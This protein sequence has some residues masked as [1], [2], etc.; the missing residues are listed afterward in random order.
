M[1]TKIYLLF[2]FICL[3]VISCDISKKVVQTDQEEQITL[4]K[5]K[6]S[7]K[8][9]LHYNF[10][11][12]LESYTQIYSR[13]PKNAED[14][15]IFIERSNEDYQMVNYNVYQFLK[16]NKSNLIFVTSVDSVTTIYNG[17]IEPNKVVI[18]ADFEQS[19]DKINLA[20]VNFFDEQGHWFRLDSLSDL[21]AD[22][23][24][25]EYWR[26]LQE[27]KD[28]RGNG[29]TYTRTILEYTPA[30]LKDLCNN[31]TLNVEQSK[32]FEN[33]I[34]FLDS[35]ASNYNISRITAPSFIDN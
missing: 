17:K 24:K 9:A 3:L 20:Q 27:T 31:K 23:L 12:I 32:F 28:R 6:W 21:V 8:E 5:T 10:W 18:K 4:T 2:T 19:C 13:S 25:T 26:Y 11:H 14:L 1:V 35:L 29:I 33:T 16:K 7:K 15:M 34:D 30:R 22:R